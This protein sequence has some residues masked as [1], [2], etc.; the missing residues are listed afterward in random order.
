MSWKRRLRTALDGAA[1]N[2]GV[3]RGLERRRREQP[4]VLM[5]HRVLPREECEGYPFPS[6]VLARELFEA[7]V[8]WLAERFELRTLSGAFDSARP[9]S[10]PVAVLTFDDG[11]RDNH[12][13]AAP[14]L[15]RHGARGTFFVASDFV[16]GRAPLWYDRAATAASALAPSQLAAA[17]QRAAVRAPDATLGGAALV[18]AWV[19]ALKQAEPKARLALV[20]AWEALAPAPASS[21]SFAPMT[22][23]QVAE[24][25]ARGHEIGA[26][27]LSHALL[28]QCDDAELARELEQS[29][30]EIASWRGGS[31]DS[32]CYP[33]GSHDE[34]VV[35]ATARAGF[36]LACTTRA[37][38]AGAALDL[39]RI[40]RID[41]TRERIADRVGRFDPLALRAE[42][43][44]FHEALR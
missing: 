12:E 40:P 25:S 11:Y 30:A 43:A 8:A 39:L 16:A 29:R 1:Q 35:A 13:H 23:A 17:A 6:L 28:P 10:R 20:E 9:A 14:I 37:P 42:L 5:H 4:T 15:E 36:R 44:G 2:L 27:S 38:V 22:P 34:R 32:F 31:V 19:E 21:A 41:I 26:H 18:R 24:L 33:D 3:L 7:E